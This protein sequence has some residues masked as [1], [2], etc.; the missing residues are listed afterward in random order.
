MSIAPPDES[1]PR[2]R[3]RIWRDE[4]EAVRLPEAG[5]W[6]SETLGRRCELVFMPEDV[7]RP[8]NPTFARAGEIVGFADGY[9]VL[10]VSEGSLADL[11]GRLGEASVPMTRFR[12]N[13]VVSTAEPFAED[14]WGELEVGSARLCGVKA[15]DR[16]AVPTVDQQTGERRGPEPIRTLSRY[17]RLGEEGA[18]IFFGQNLLVRRPGKIAVGDPVLVLSYIPAVYQS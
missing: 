7:R 9:P 1:A 2:V 5:R 6:A 4:V 13:V 16:C 17:R 18:G 12:P 11:N 3:V 15:S 10:L 14:G 8:V